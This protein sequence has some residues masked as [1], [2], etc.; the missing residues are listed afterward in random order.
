MP[1]SHETVELFA[2]AVEQDIN[3]RDSW[4]ASRDFRLHLARELARRCL[5]ESIRLNGGE[6]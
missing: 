6:L 1:V 4:R 2:E 5:T 3:P